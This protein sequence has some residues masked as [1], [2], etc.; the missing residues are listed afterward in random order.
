MPKAAPPSIMHRIIL[1]PLLQ[2][3]IKKKKLQR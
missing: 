2:W 3:K 1:M